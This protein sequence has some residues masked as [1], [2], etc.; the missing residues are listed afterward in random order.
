MIAAGSG[1]QLAAH[2]NAS[3]PTQA[4]CTRTWLQQML[5]PCAL[6][7]AAAMLGNTLVQARTVPWACPWPPPPRI[8]HCQSLQRGTGNFQSAFLKPGCMQQGGRSRFGRRRRQEVCWMLQRGRDSKQPHNAGA[9]PC[10]TRQRSRVHVGAQLLRQ[11]RRAT[12]PRGG[13]HQQD[14]AGK[15]GD[16]GRQLLPRVLCAAPSCG[17]C[18]GVWAT[19]MLRRRR[20][21][22]AGLPSH[23]PAAAARALWPHR[24][25]RRNAPPARGS[26]R[27]RRM[28]CASEL[29]AQRVQRAVLAPAS[30]SSPAAPPSTSSCRRRACSGSAAAAAAAAPCPRHLRPPGMWEMR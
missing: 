4:P 16:Q 28:S 10:E 8:G 2:T 23:A 20:R 3:V 22:A 13:V 26:L 30:S 19:L 12:E 15:P 6:P 21:P 11:G 27:R 7:A 14:A 5:V 1:Q 17:G 24:R 9:W 18:G 29:H 25:R